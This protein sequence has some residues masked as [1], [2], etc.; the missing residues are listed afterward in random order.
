MK[1][2]PNISI[3]KISIDLCAVRHRIRIKNIFADIVYNVLV[4]KMS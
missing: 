2:K 3:S 4:L 1:I